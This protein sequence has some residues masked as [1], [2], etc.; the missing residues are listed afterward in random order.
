M[1]DFAGG[2]MGG[3][4][5][6]VYNTPFNTVGVGDPVAPGSGSEMGSGDMFIPVMGMA[7]K[8]PAYT[9]SS[10]NK[11]TKIPHQ[12]SMGFSMDPRPLIVPINGRSGDTR[13]TT[14][15]PKK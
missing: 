4:G 11:K 5:G 9:Q 12:E 1:C 2:N 14:K 3:A 7:T 13:K 10:S 8:R 15:A 6:G